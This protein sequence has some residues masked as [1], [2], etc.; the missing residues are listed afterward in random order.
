MKIRLCAFADEGGTT[1]E[2]QIEALRANNINLVELRSI[3]GRNI[4]KISEDEARAC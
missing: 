3:D 1:I 2:E 4:S